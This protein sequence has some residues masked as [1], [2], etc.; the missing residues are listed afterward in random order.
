MAQEV[1]VGKNCGVVQVAMLLLA[2]YYCA[3]VAI[4]ESRLLAILDSSQSFITYSN[5]GLHNV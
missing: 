3:Y 1:H 5:L 4:T 2:T